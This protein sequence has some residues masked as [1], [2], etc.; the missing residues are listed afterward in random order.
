M[1]EQV[2]QREII[3]NMFRN[4]PRYNSRENEDKILEIAS[5]ESGGATT[6]N[7]GVAF[8]RL[9]YGGQLVTNQE[10]EIEEEKVRVQAEQS[11][12]EWV[13]TTYLWKQ[14]HLKD[15]EPT[16]ANYNKL[17]A[18][19]NANQLPLTYQSL[20]KAFVA[21]K[22]QGARFVAEKELPPLPEVPGMG[23]PQIFTPSDITDMPPERYKKL[24][25]GRSS[26]QFRARITEILRRAKE[27]E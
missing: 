21:L 4:W 6:Q 26:V 12:T 20:E 9:Y 7:I 14:D 10:H 8:D 13:R 19:F 27:E 23:E 25:F 2:A 15:Y 24:Y 16:E 11:K 3:R 22:A 5:G 18:Y 1:A 17:A